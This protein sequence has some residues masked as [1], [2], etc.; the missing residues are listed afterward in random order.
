MCPQIKMTLSSVWCNKTQDDTGNDDD[1]DDNLLAFVIDNINNLHNFLLVTFP[2]Q[3]IFAGVFS[4][5]KGPP[6]YHTKPWLKA[7]VGRFFLSLCFVNQ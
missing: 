5:E 1:A 2:K 3:S 4:G 6:F 7:S